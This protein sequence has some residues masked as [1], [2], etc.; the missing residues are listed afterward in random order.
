MD[1][2]IECIAEVQSASLAAAIRK[3]LKK[4]IQV[5]ERSHGGSTQAVLPT[6]SCAIWFGE[7]R[8]QASTTWMHPGGIGYVIALSSKEGEYP[9]PFGASEFIW[10]KSPDQLAQRV[11]KLLN[12]LKKSAD[13]RI[14]RTRMV[15]GREIEVLFLDGEV[16][17][18]P[19]DGKYDWSQVRVAP[20]RRYLI[21]PRNGGELETIPWDAI[22]R[23]DSHLDEESRTQRRLAETL[24]NLRKEADF[25]QA[26]AARASGLARQTIIRLE[27]AGNYPGLKTLRALAKAYGLT[28]EELLRRVGSSQPG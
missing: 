9:L 19:L 8:R 26:E 2:G 11:G 16:F 22:R 12:N 27:K 4:E 14:V 10:A 6:H 24:R 13:Q 7:L 17:S 21:V 23:P 18:L 28:V 15:S 25:T 5:F 20:D 1:D 3:R